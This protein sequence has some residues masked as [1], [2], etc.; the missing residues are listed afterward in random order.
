MNQRL[1]SLR[2]DLIL[3]TSTMALFPDKVTFTSTGRLALQH[4]SGVAGGEDNPTHN[5]V[6][7]NLVLE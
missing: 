6:Y 4:V 2:Y 1:T 5:Q 3:I 7:T